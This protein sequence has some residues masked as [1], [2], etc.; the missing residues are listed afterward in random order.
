[1]II[2]IDVFRL[3]C[4]DLGNVVNDE[5]LSRTFQKYPSFQKGKM[6]RDKRTGKT[7]G[8]VF[9]LFKD[10]TDFIKAM[11]EMDSQFKFENIQL[12]IL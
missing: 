11:R 12:K 8:H 1:M 5:S 7:K 9:V 2:N 6:I 4:G 3:F 10:S